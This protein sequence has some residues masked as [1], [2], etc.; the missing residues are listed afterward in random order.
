MPSQ[1]FDHVVVPAGGLTPRSFFVT[2][3]QCVGCHAAGST[4]L[5]YDMT[6]QLPAE[7]GNLLIDL[8]PYGTWRASPMGLAGRDPI[9]FAQLASETQTFHPEVAPLIESTCLGC[10]GAQGQRQYFIDRPDDSSCEPPF[11]RAYLDATPYPSNNPMAR[12]GALAR[13]GL[14]CMACHRMVLGEAENTKYRDSPQNRCIYARQDYLFPEAT[15]FART[16]TGSFLVGNPSKM[17]GPFPE[18]KDLPMRRALGIVPEHNPSIKSSELCGTCHTIHLPVLRGQQILGHFYEQTTYPEWAFSGYRTGETPDGKL[19]GGKGANAQSCQDCHM[20]STGLNGKPIRS[21][22][23]SIQERSNFPQV[24]HALPAEDIDLPV[25]EGPARHSLV[26]LNLFLVQMAKQFSDT[27]GMSPSS[28]MLQDLGVNPIDFSSAEIVDQA[29]WNTADIAIL[30]ATRGIKDIA[31]TVR[32]GNKTGH[33]FPSGVAFRR[34]FVDFRVTDP[35]GKVLW[36]SGR[37]D[38]QGHIID[39]KGDPVAGEVWWTPDCSARPGSDLY[40]PHFET[41]V[42]QDQVQ[43][44]QQLT[45][46]P[47]DSGPARCGVEYAT[48]PM[49]TSFLSICGRV[50]DNRLLPKGFL[51]IKDR[52][53]I[54]K[55]LGAQE[56]L[57]YE[58]NAIGVGNDPDYKGGGDT[59]RFLVPLKEINGVPAKVEATLYYQAIPPYYLQDRRCTAKGTDADRLRAITGALDLSNTPAAGWKLKLVS[60]GPVA[61]TP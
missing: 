52:I 46:A 60:T 12:Y 17:D 36:E 8:S 40:Q 25:R 19:P 59:L 35:N 10:H 48:G 27:L 7:S 15:G 31:A 21:K 5:Q 32:I 22:I 2:S 49:T 6:E 51:P 38:P 24:D 39:Q 3:D 57:A 61:I 41:I 54:A 56:D 50:K 58:T 29:N 34:A 37:T 18:P 43:I 28:S 42:R 20:P 14:A 16:F 44:Y 30:S 13:D 9:F 23:A 55:A 53:A 45:T 47:P 26:G 4:G 1:A 33:K 11:L